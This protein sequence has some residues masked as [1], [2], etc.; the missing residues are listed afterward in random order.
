MTDS[1]LIELLITDR[2]A[3]MTA[4][5]KQYS[6]FVFAI[7]RPI[8][9]DVCDSSE[10]EDCVTDVFLN[11]YSAL[12][13][14]KPDASIKSYL[15]KIAR[16]A[17]LSIVRSK[18]PAESL[19]DDDF[20]IEIPDGTELSRS[21]AEKELLERVFLQIKLL[22]RPSSDIIFRKYYLGQSSKQIAEELKMTVSNVDTRAHRAL[23]KLKTKLK[24]EIL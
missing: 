11:F 10:I 18:V 20:P 15:G 16:N 14:Y 3:G 4:L 5:I 7:V 1:K 6:G 24:G 9:T 21:L 8:L 22:G 13:R 23:Q 19:D 12:H 2:N 17:S